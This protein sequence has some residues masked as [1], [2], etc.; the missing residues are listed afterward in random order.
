MRTTIPG[1]PVSRPIADLL[2]GVFIEHDPLL[3]SFTAGFDDTLAPIPG[4]LDS[5]A[6]YID[7]WLAPADFVSWLATWVGL[8]LDEAW[9]IDRKRDAVASAVEIY[10]HLGSAAGLQRYLELVT[11]GRV[12][13]RE[14]GGIAI[15]QVPGAEL[16]GEPGSRISI[17]IHVTDP[18]SVDMG[19]LER[20]VAKAKPA[21]VAHTIEVVL[22]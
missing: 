5:L 15:S 18:T 21:W 2:P 11:G 7:P 9:P 8:E 22:A 1:L 6:A 3:I 12:E 16:P 19:T 20:S 13:V 17:R 14:T 4:T 10:Q